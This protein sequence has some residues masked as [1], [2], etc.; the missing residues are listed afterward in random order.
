MFWPPRLR[1][2]LARRGWQNPKGALEPTQDGGHENTTAT[3]PIRGAPEGPSNLNRRAAVGVVGMGGLPK[4]SLADGGL[5]LR[6][7]ISTG[8]RLGASFS[9]LQ[10]PS[11]WRDRA[12]SRWF[13]GVYLT[14]IVF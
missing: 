10:P 9:L 5:G 6:A 2:D 7:T 11:P 12:K 4:R 1:N 8:M 13:F 14:Q 3:A